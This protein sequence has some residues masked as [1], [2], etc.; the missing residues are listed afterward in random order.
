MA[1]NLQW[2]T[3]G[4]REF[5]EGQDWPA[6]EIAILRYLYGPERLTVSDGVD[7]YVRE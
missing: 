1:V 7:Q 3:G 5:R 2:F 6:D 4:P